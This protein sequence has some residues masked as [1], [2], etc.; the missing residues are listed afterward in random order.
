MIYNSIINAR[1]V[2]KKG[3][4]MF[5]NNREQLLERLLMQRE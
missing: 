3:A 5:I 2:P 1:S 4:Q